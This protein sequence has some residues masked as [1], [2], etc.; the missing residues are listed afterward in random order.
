MGWGCADVGPHRGCAATLADRP[1]RRAQVGPQHAPRLGDL[2][3][4]LRRD[5]G[6]SRGFRR[7]QCC[8]LSGMLIF[9]NVGGGTHL[10]YA[11]ARCCRR[12]S[13]QLSRPLG[14][15]GCREG[16]SNCVRCVEQND[17]GRLP[18]LGRSVSGAAAG[19]FPDPEV[20]SPSPVRAR[21][22]TSLRVQGRSVGTSARRDL[23]EET[24]CGGEQSRLA[25]S[26][27]PGVT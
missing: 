23:T 4:L 18:L 12:H 20:D 13:V 11:G 21:G 1:I 9:V 14:S 24:V 15:A 19:R 3:A 17:R 2:A 22:R 27:Q 26:G 16:G 8:C 25:G 7:L 5:Y 10:G 6:A